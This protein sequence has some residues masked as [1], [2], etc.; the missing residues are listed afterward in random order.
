MTQGNSRYERFYLRVR[1]SSPAVFAAARVVTWCA[2]KARRY[3]ILTIAYLALVAGLLV[4]AFTVEFEPY[5]AALLGA[6]GLAIAA[7][8]LFV[9]VGF[10][11]FLLKEMHHDL[12][13]KHLNLRRRVERTEAVQRREPAS[14]SKVD[15]R[16][17][18]LGADVSALAKRLDDETA[19]AR[20][21]EDNLQ[22]RLERERG[23]TLGTLRDRL[24]DLFDAQTAMRDSLAN[25]LAAIRRDGDSSE[26]KAEVERL[27]SEVE[28]D[29]KGR[30]GELA[31]LE[32]GRDVQGLEAEVQRLRSELEADRRNLA[33]ELAALEPGRD[34]QG[35]K[36]EV[37]RMRSELESDRRAFA[38]H[39][40]ALGSHRDPSRLEAEIERLRSQ[41][42]SLA[43]EVAGSIPGRDTIAS[44][45]AEIE[46]M[47]ND[48]AAL[49][50]KLD[51]EISAITS[52]Q[53]VGHALESAID[54][55]NSAQ[56][57]TQA[58]LIAEIRMREQAGQGDDFED[59]FNPAPSHVTD[60]SQP[61]S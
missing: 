50:G 22:V 34:L 57:A 45:R 54:Q 46:R 3:P 33:R 30:A 53:N 26:L 38:D 23:V 4:G 55:L 7:G 43:A 9:T 32:P 56:E 47:E 12:S 35:L 31:A 52:R 48:H 1:D 25:E 14:R 51:A 29:R 6:A 24:A 40:A 5:G 41:H 13:I 60:P 16:L 11:R 28:S 15:V 18:G 42:D 8:G 36:T 21:L 20:R 59:Q 10:N 49:F 2:R 44:L 19:R 58:A 27:R 37:E 61:R 17:Q 39:L